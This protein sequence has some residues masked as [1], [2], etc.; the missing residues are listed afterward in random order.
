MILGD[1]FWSIGLLAVPHGQNN[2]LGLKTI[3]IG[4]LDRDCVASHFAP[5][6][7]GPNVEFIQTQTLNQLL[8]MGIE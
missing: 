8:A 4:Q 7:P 2:L 1:P 5:N 3:A 6:C